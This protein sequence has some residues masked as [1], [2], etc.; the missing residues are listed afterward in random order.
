[1]PTVQQ[2]Q[3][4]LNSK[5]RIIYEMETAN[6]WQWLGQYVDGEPVKL[7]RQKDISG[8]NIAQ[9]LL[10]FKK[11]LK[12]ALVQ[13]HAD[14]QKVLLVEQN[15]LALKEEIQVLQEILSKSDRDPRDARLETL[16]GRLR[17]YKSEI[18]RLHTKISIADRIA[19][20][21]TDA[22]IK[23]EA[24][25]RTLHIELEKQTALA[26]RSIAPSDN[27]NSKEQLELA[28]SELEDAGKQLTSTSERL[29][30]ISAENAG[31]V[32]AT[33]ENIEQIRVL[34]IE[35]QELTWKRDQAEIQIKKFQDRM[36][37]YTIETVE[38][39]ELESKNIQ[40]EL[41][42]TKSALKE[43]E[44]SLSF[45]RQDLDAAQMKL[46]QYIARLHAV[47]ANNDSVQ[48]DVD[49]LKNLQDENSKHQLEIEALKNQAKFHEID[50][51]AQLEVHTEQELEIKQLQQKI[52]DMQ[53]SA[54]KMTAENHTQ[55][56]LIEDYG[57]AMA[58]YESKLDLA[59]RISAKS[60]EIL[61]SENE[62]AKLATT[63]KVTDQTLESTAHSIETD[64]L[65]HTISDLHISLKSALAES[66]AS[67]EYQTTIAEMKLK[68]EKQESEIDTLT[69]HISRE[70]GDGDESLAK[71]LELELQET[72]AQIVSMEQVLQNSNVA[73]NNLE[74]D[75]DRSAREVKELASLLET[76]NSEIDNLQ[77]QLIENR[78][79]ATVSQLENAMSD[80][81]SSKLKCDSIS[82]QLASSQCQV[83]SLATQ[84]GSKDEQ[85]TELLQSKNT[86]LSN[87]PSDLARTEYS[88][89]VQTNLKLL[90]KIKDLSQKLAD[91]DD[92]RRATMDPGLAH[93]A[94]QTS[95]MHH[96][97]AANAARDKLQTVEGDLHASFRKLSILGMEKAELEEAIED[98]KFENVQLKAQLGKSK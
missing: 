59:S 58:I 7:N 2:L 88:E 79:A 47:E 24:C 23:A 48:I 4:A 57:S 29:E 34:N 30:A 31:L 93:L 78:N 36:G 21:N 38:Q 9:E 37:S 46:S 12:D 1:M 26:A 80:L 41:V 5:D 44:N 84:L 60:V 64:A 6:N 83:D 51:E 35:C 16:Q 22:R 76:K 92:Q 43:A 63:G 77:N 18:S 97:E 17:D 72:K 95:L 49:S 15:E 89:L 13:V 54:E 75:V 33:A 65:K 98:L 70:V 67:S 66:A 81:E 68:I 14:K 28:Q 73:V 87:S 74:S 10:S 90:E 56:L 27:A 91:F 32:A 86:E 94:L 55:S 69:D 25:Q 40:E 96:D 62:I 42:S 3:D 20:R 8:K 11:S 71:H 61:N 85:L 53:K 39:L 45:S 82:Q 19:K 52:A 50:M